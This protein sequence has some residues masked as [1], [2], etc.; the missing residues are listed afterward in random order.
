MGNNPLIQ[1]GFEIRPWAAHRATPELTGGFPEEIADAA[2]DL[3]RASS[4]SEPD[5]CQLRYNSS[6]LRPLFTEWVCLGACLPSCLNLYSLA[7]HCK[8]ICLSWQVSVEMD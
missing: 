1:E 3:T 8:G 6:T 7:P 4:E 5:Q 2:K